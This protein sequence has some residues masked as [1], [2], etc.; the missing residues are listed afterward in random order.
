MKKLIALLLSVTM[1]FGLAGAADGAF[2]KKEDSVTDKTLRFSED[3]KFTILQIAD[4]QDCILLRDMTKDFICYLLDTVNPDLVVLTGDNVGPNTCLT[5]GLTVLTIDTFMSIF[6]ERGIKVA[7][8]YGNHD[9]DRN[10]LNKDEQ[11]KLYEKY[12]CYVGSDVP[13]LSGTGTYNLPI[14]ASDSDKT[15]FNLWFFDSGEKNDENDLGGYGCVHKD[16]IEWYIETEKALTE[17]NGGVTVP[18]MAFQHIIIPEIYDVLKE[19]SQE[20]KADYEGEFLAER[21]GKYY[22]FPKEYKNEDTYFSETPCPPNYTNGQADALVEN[23]KVLGIVSGHDHKNSFIIPY[24]GMDII[25]SPTSSL[26]SYGDFNRGAR[27]ITLNEKNLSEYDTDIIYM[28]EYFDLNDE[29]TYY[30]FVYNNEGG[31]LNIPEMLIYMVKFAFN[32]LGLFAQTVL[33]VWNS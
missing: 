21:D 17:K 27:V 26:G 20:E 23:G 10:R 19:V 24:K 6:E 16:Q 22:A 11:Q 14:L 33:R 12:S 2:C 15:A 28:R 25:Q 18:S 9:A 4:I 32:K 29:A 7:S 13:D 1:I 31:N 3:G 5:Y 30:R 8:V